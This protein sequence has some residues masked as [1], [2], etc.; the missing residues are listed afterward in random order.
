[1]KLSKSLVALVCIFALALCSWFLT[2]FIK[3][4]STQPKVKKYIGT[5]DGCILDNNGSFGTLAECEKVNKR[6][7][8]NWP[9]INDWY[10]ASGLEHRTSM[11]RF[12]ENV[13]FVVRR[14]YDF[15][16]MTN[17]HKNIHD[18][19]VEI[20]TGVNNVKLSL[21]IRAGNFMI[22]RTDVNSPIGSASITIDGTVLPLYVVF[23]PYNK[24]DSVYMP[25]QQAAEYVLNEKGYVFQGGS[26]ENCSARVWRYAQFN[27]TI[28]TAVIDLLE[29][30]YSKFEEII[31][32]RYTPAVNMASPIDVS[33]Y[34]SCAGNAMVLTGNWSKNLEKDVKAR[35]AKGDKYVKAPWE[36]TGSDD[37]FDQYMARKG[38]SGI[39]FPVVDFGQC[40]V[41][42]GILNS[43]CRSIGIPCRQITNFSSAHPNCPTISGLGDSGITVCDYSQANF[44]NVM[45]DQKETASGDYF[46]GMVWN[47]HSWN[48]AWMK[49]DD[50]P[51]P[52]SGWQAIDSTLQEQSAGIGRMG[53]AS[54]FAIKSMN[55][56][57]NYDTSFVIAEVNWIVE[58]NDKAGTKLPGSGTP[59]SS[60]PLLADYVLVRPNNIDDKDEDWDYYK[61]MPQVK[62]VL[63]PLAIEY[64]PDKPL[65]AIRPL[66]LTHPGIK[67]SIPTATI[68]SK[69]PISVQVFPKIDETITVR[70]MGILTMYTGERINVPTVSYQHETIDVKA[71]Q[72]Q[73][74]MFY[75]NT[76]DIDLSEANYIKFLTSVILDKQQYTDVNSTYIKAPLTELNQKDKSSIE[77]IFTNPYKNKPLTGVQIELTGDHVVRD[78]IM[79]GT[80]EPG[81]TYKT[82]RP[83]RTDI[84]PHYKMNFITVSSSLTCNEICTPSSG[85]ISQFKV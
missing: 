70:I 11:Y 14:G 68:S 32:K 49:R 5:P 48:D 37:I 66:D 43:M 81:Q 23:N 83:V 75:V 3:R 9:H 35:R 28:L 41:F 44:T 78:V 36:W 62:T 2:R 7:D 82:T 17:K 79:V 69:I 77:I 39:S 47:F 18:A 38:T 25:E 53:P 56:M 65:A 80:I 85:F 34:L 24:L 4:G 26:T 40:W 27:G 71:G 67:T 31:G 30:M 74:V 61:D 8:P 19:K 1:M 15:I 76:S 52:Y 33:R 29:G 60:I 54:L 58:L 64:K 6:F 72:P 46:N 45:F 20:N 21:V 16:I 13:R 22:F 51:E 12:A 50:L 73:I 63:Q 57:V 10:F 42:G 55:P 59:V 84:Q